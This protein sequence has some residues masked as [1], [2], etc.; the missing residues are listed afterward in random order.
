MRDRSPN[1]IKTSNSYLG[2][3]TLSTICMYILRRGD[4]TDM[5]MEMEMEMGAWGGLLWLGGSLA[6]GSTA[7]TQDM[8]VASH[9]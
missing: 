7:K 6:W 9:G 3:Y 1:T 5:E 2:I 8:H 4:W